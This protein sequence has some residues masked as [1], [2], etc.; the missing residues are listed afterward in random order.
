[1]SIL[2]LILR[3]LKVCV[4]LCPSAAAAGKPETFWFSTAPL[5]SPR[6]FLTDD[7]DFRVLVRLVVLLQPENV[8]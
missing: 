1:M 8:Q 7:Y 6:Y 4:C 2:Y 3:V 5:E